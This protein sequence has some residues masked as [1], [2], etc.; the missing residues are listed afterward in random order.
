MT[1]TKHDNLNDRQ[2]QPI[3]SENN[4]T[5]T[6]KVDVKNMPKE[7]GLKYNGPEPTRYGDWV[8][9]GKCVDF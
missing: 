2:E 5:I 7:Y 9:K 8:I 3:T 6:K 4:S 1:N